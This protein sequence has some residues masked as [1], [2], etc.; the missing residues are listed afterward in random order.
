MPAHRGATPPPGSQTDPRYRCGHTGS[1]IIK[2][3]ELIDLDDQWLARYGI[4]T[5]GAV[6]VR[7]DGYVVWRHPYPAHNPETALT[8]ALHHILFGEDSRGDGSPARSHGH[9]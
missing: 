5:G 3:V 9:Q 7:P 2:Q 8:D 1:G 4:A 6:L